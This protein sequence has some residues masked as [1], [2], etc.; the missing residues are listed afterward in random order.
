[1]GMPGQSLLC[2]WKLAGAVLRDTLRGYV[3][4]FMHRTH[5]ISLSLLA[6]APVCRSQG[7]SSGKPGRLHGADGGSGI[8]GACIEHRAHL[9]VRSAGTGGAVA[10]AGV[11][12]HAADVGKQGSGGV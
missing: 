1:P 6:R 3:I 8:A 2:A 12:S 7:H 4:S 11:Y 5:A 10:E 9:D